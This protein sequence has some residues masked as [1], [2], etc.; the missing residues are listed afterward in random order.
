MSQSTDSAQGNGR[1]LNEVVARTER[2]GVIGSRLDDL[3]QVFDCLLVFAPFLI[4]RRTHSAKLG[5]LAKL[6]VPVVSGPV[7]RSSRFMGLNQ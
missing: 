4:E 5:N 2:L 3:D 1:Q 6:P 7:E